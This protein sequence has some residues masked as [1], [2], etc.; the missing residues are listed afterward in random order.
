MNTRKGETTCCLITGTWPNWVAHVASSR[1]QSQEGYPYICL[2]RIRRT[3]T[4]RTKNQLLLPC[5]LVHCRTLTELPVVT[6]QTWKVVCFPS[7]DQVSRVSSGP[8]LAQLM[9]KVLQVERKK[10]DKNFESRLTCKPGLTNWSEPAI[11]NFANR[12]PC[13]GAAHLAS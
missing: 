12:G 7:D 4:V 9:S 6:V 5:G 3:K 11:A 10:A 1:K 13:L 8:H 2:F